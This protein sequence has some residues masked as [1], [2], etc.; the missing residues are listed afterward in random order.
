MCTGLYG[1][2][3]KRALFDLRLKTPLS[4]HTMHNTIAITRTNISQL[5]QT[6]LM[7]RHAFLMLSVFLQTRGQKWHPLK[8][9]CEVFWVGTRLVLLL[10]RTFHCNRLMSQNTQSVSYRGRRSGEG[11]VHTYL[12]EQGTVVFDGTFLNSQCELLQGHFGNKNSQHQN[13]VKRVFLKG[14]IFIIKNESE[15]SFFKNR[16]LRIWNP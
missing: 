2:S 9:L 12:C 5:N 8:S 11:T 4:N 6:I 10:L 14:H 16:P 7:K 3:L 13:K 1:E 15:L